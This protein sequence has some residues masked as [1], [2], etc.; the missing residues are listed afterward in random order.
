MAGA[1]FDIKS[2]ATQ[3]LYAGAGVVDLAVEVV[4]EYVSS[5]Q[6]KVNEVQGDVQTRVKD[7]QE[8]ATSFKPE[9]L[10]SSVT[11]EAKERRAAIETKIA[12]LQAEAKALPEKAKKAGD[13]YAASVNSAYEDLA[14]RG[15]TLVARIRNQESTKEAVKSTKST[16]ARAK[17]TKTSATKTAA[18]ATTTAKTASTTAKKTAKETA[19]TATTTAKKASTAPTKGAATTTRKRAATTKASAKATGTTAKQTV[20]KTAAAVSD[21][22]EKIGD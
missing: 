19:Q 9:T 17:A 8:K 12:D 4:R 16:A 1:K 14:K 5:T 11:K 10:R 3:A 13:E 20:E 22:V 18:A 21:A 2:E 15:E 7:A 6:A